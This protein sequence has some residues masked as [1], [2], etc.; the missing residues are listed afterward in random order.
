MSGFGVKILLLG[1]LNHQFAKLEDFFPLMKFKIRNLGSVT[2]LEV[3]LVPQLLP[4]P[5][6]EK[7][8][9]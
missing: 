5:Q 6:P 9:G 1:F 8:L 2:L 7:I 4:F 3:D